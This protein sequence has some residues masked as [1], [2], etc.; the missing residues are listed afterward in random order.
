MIILWSHNLKV[1]ELVI[2]ATVA[3]RPHYDCCARL[4]PTFKDIHH[5]PIEPLD[6]ETFSSIFSDCLFHNLPLLIHAPIVLSRNHLHPLLSLPIRH[7]D[8][9]SAIF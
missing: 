3:L 1:P 8:A 7:L 2:V 6:E 9:L 4:S 5:H